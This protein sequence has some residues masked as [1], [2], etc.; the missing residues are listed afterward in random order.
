MAGLLCQ[1]KVQHVPA[2][3]QHVPTT[4]Y[5][6]TSCYEY[7]DLRYSRKVHMASTIA[8]SHM[9]SDC[10]PKTAKPS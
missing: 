2:I 10:C 4:L 9:P 5:E 6:T 7:G 3:N 8:H 1:A